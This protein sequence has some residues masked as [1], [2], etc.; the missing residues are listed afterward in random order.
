VGVNT[1]RPIYYLGCKTSVT[2]AIKAAI[3]EVDPSIGRVCDL[4]SGSGVVGATLSLSRQV[5]TVDIQE[6]SRVLSSAL[7]NPA[8]LSPIFIAGISREIENDSVYNQVSSILQPLIDYELRS[9]DLAIA[10]NSELLIELLEAQPIGSHDE[11]SAVNPE[12]HLTQMKKAAVSKLKIAG[13]WNSADTTVLRHFGGVYFSFSQ[14][15]MLDA[16][17]SMAARSNVKHRDTL[18]AAALSTA[19][20]LVNTVGKQFAQPIRPRHKTGGV[21]KSLAGVVK[22][23]RSLDTLDTYMAWVKRYASLR[24]ATS[25]AIA[26]RMDYLDA[27]KKHASKFSVIYA[28]PPYTRDHYSRFYHVL[29]TMCLRDNPGVSQVTKNGKVVASRGLYREDR[30]QSP[31]CIRSLAP[32]A[33]SNLFETA[34]QHNLPL[35]LSYSPHEMGDGTHPRVVSMSQ[36]IEIAST[37]Y[38][39]VEVSTIDGVSHNQLNR[40]GLKLKSRDHAEVLLKCFI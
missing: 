24:P 3:D 17:L 19:S 27:L 2:S 10:G 12:F 20:A 13:L 21:K 16:I 34:K 40:N 31:F 30:H 5:T 32:K 4:F 26:L 11:S 14:A 37:Y 28:D 8:K 7:L 18:T 33:F 9:I 15:I 23:D 36:I 1:F 25:K 39:R 22:R 29:E 6:Y 38:K 35:V